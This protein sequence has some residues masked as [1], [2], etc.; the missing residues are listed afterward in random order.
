MNH[1]DDLLPRSS[2]PFRLHFHNGERPGPDRIEL[3]EHLAR[4]R[5]ISGAA[6]AMGVA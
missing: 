2:A 3:L 1:P 6:R 4:E 5:T